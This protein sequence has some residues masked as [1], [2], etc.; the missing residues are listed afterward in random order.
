MTTLLQAAIEF[1]R[2]RGGES[3]DNWSEEHGAPFLNDNCRMAFM[4][5]AAAM[6][7]LFASGQAVKTER[8]PGKY[9]FQCDGYSY[10]EE[11]KIVQGSYIVTAYDISDARKLAE[12]RALKRMK[13]PTWTE[14]RIA[15]DSDTESE[16]EVV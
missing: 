3:F 5:G 10:G 16:K 15:L 14:V 12:F 13:Y 2:S 1:E 6:A 7:E 8:V 4:A 9:F 11:S